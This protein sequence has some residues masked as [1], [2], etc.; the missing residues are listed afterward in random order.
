MNGPSCSTARVASDFAST[1]G[2]R[3]TGR[4][5]DVAMVMPAACSTTADNAVSPSSHGLRQSR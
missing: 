4:A 3:T 2:W 1:T 5:T